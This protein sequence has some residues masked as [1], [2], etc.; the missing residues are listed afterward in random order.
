[1]TTDLNQ[2][3]APLGAEKIGRLLWTYSVPAIIG[4]VVASLYNIIDRIY[5]G[6]GV[7]SLAISGLG[8]TFPL[9]GLVTA[10]GTLVGVGAAARLSIVLGMQDLKWARN[11]LGNSLILTL[12][13][14]ALITTLSMI[15]MDEILIAFG[16]SAQ[17]IPY[18][19]EYLRIVMPGS[20]LLNLSYSF[21]N[22]MRA[23][24]Y[25][26]KSMVT[27]LI[28]VGLNVI[29]DPIFI[30]GF[31]MGIRGAAIATVLSM[32]VSTLFVMHHFASRKHPVRFCRDCF[33]LKSYIIINIISIGMSPFLTNLLASGVN[34]IMNNLLVREGGDLAIGAFSII[35][36]YAVL[37]V[38][39]VL[40]VCQGMQPIVG[41]NY[42]AQQLDRMKHAL[43][44]TI[45]VAVLI[46]TGGFLACELIPHT[47]VRAFTSDPQLEALAVQ[48]M[49]LAY[50]MLP[51]VGFQ[52]VVSVFFQAISKASKAIIMSATRQAIFLIP[53][54]Y[55]LSEPWGLTGVWLAMP[56]S[57]LCASLVALLF[58]RQ[59]RRIYTPT[60]E[61]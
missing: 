6:Q 14:S 16:G 31:D 38:M 50:L 1:M 59:A 48:G 4:M 9:M 45:R 25:P 44:L 49:R 61:V 42:G 26:K 52:I 17:T 7:G 28:G 36:S 24:G 10:F 32:S 41:Y 57:D 37:I 39:C 40:G 55:L 51:I 2:A 47:L 33:R 15:Y 34:V 43:W 35:N 29:L 22:M 54:L 27:I 11:I 19:E 12:L 46:T 13:L 21:S 60:P 30:F 58:L 3:T 23:T 53:A 18:A 8:L 56:L 20:V 5:I